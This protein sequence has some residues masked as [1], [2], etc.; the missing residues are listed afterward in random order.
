MAAV[1]PS[2]EPGSRSLA[3]ASRSEASVADRGLGLLEGAGVGAAAK[4]A[5]RSDRADS[6]Q[7][8]AHTLPLALAGRS[9]QQDPQAAQGNCSTHIGRIRL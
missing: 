1:Q 2:L 5:I 6:A 4:R 3:N 8:G 9:K 7:E